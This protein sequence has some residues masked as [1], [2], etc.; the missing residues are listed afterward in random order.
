MIRA[1][2]NTV[3]RTLAA[4]LAAAALVSVSQAVGSADA[5]GLREAADSAYSK[6]VGY[7]AA[8]DLTFTH[9]YLSDY[10]SAL[11][12][13]HLKGEAT[14]AEAATAAA[15]RD[16]YL[17]EPVLF[18]EDTERDSVF[19]GTN[20]RFIEGSSGVMIDLTL[21]ID[22]V[23]DHM[24]RI[25]AV[26]EELMVLVTLSASGERAMRS[27][28]FGRSDAYLRELAASLA[29]LEGRVYLAYEPRVNLMKN[30]RTLAD[31]Y[32]SSYRYLSDMI[33]RYAP[34][35]SLVYG[36][37]DVSLPGG[38][39][40]AVYYPGDGYVDAVGVSLCH[41]YVGDG[42][43][44]PQTAYDRR[45]AYYSPVGSVLHTAEELRAVAGESLPLIVLGA[46]FPWGG[47]LKLD[48]PIS[49]MQKFYSVLPTVCHGLIGV[50][51]TN[52]STAVAHCNTR[53]NAEAEAALRACASLPFYKYYGDDRADSAMCAAAS[54]THLPADTPVRFS[55]WCGDIYG[56][57]TAEAFLNGIRAEDGILFPIGDS[58]LQLY[59]TGT[60]I[61]SRSV[62]SV[63]VTAEGHLSL[64][65]VRETDFDF[66]QNGILDFG[67]TQYLTAVVAKWN[68]TMP[69]GTVTDVNGD[70]KVNLTDVALLKSM[71]MPPQ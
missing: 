11:E 59:V 1:F 61:Y 2:S 55:V 54:L 52:L 26:A 5:D 63:T 36:V 10:A 56:A 30:T 31:S 21:G 44:D 71:M 49:E 14:A 58:T 12:A 3:R 24:H 40:A 57:C 6:A 25:P 47:A 43:M 37:A 29:T 13:L 53:Q 16:T 38:S 18:L 32:V 70:G 33:R 19:F 50:F 69:E 48:S 28:T 45:G 66:N 22:T 20:G 41:T 65:P 8:G 67:D 64:T 17:Y 34:N 15:L 35:V 27:V 60:Q 4:F 68:I 23:T 51:Y 39:A 42:T 62:Y 9:K 7:E 46:S